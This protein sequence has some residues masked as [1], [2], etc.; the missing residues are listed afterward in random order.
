MKEHRIL[1]KYIVSTIFVMVIMLIN[2]KVN[3]A[4]LSIKASKSTVNEGDSVTITVSSTY[5]GRVNIT[6]SAGSLSNSKVWLENNEQSVTLKANAKDKITVTATPSGS[7]S[8]SNGEKVDVQSASTTITIKSSDSNGGSNT[9]KVDDEKPKEPTF[10]STEEKVYA[11]GNANIRKSYSADSEKV[12]GVEKGESLTR[13]GVGD[14]GWSKVTYDG[15]TGYIKSSLLTTEEP[16]KSEDKTLKGLSVEG[17]E[18]DPAFDS[19]ITEYSVSVGEDVEKLDI[20]VTPNDENA[21]FDIAGNEALQVGDNI[22]KI[23]VTAEDQTT[24]LYTINVAKQAKEALSLSSLKVDGYALNPKFSPDILEYKLTIQDPDVNNINIVA[25]SNIENAKVEVVG[26][27][28]LKQGEN[29]I[30]INVASEDGQEN[31][32]YKIIANKTNVSVA[33]T[34]QSNWIL[35]VGIGAI[36]ILVLLII[37]VVVKAKKKANPRNKGNLDSQDYSDLYGIS[38]ND[39]K[40]AYSRQ[41]YDNSE[42]EENKYFKNDLFGKLT[43]V[44]I[45]DNTPQNTNGKYEDGFSYNPYSTADIYEDNYKAYSTINSKDD[46]IPDGSVPSQYNSELDYD[47]EDYRGRKTRGKHSK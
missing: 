26:N 16:K 11:T 17:Y 6:A 24:R 4:G 34:N 22:I 13:I 27:T 37:I 25:L 38:S 47:E 35:Y 10:K 45:G 1:V 8:N 14:N 44:D 29:V 39:N 42:M 7:M 30:Q 3:A 28:D 21:K 15:E 31:I 20:K 40:S 23:T 19:E 32:T 43:D 33:S 18:M 41:D 9:N 5:T 46:E 12:G 2:N 36:L